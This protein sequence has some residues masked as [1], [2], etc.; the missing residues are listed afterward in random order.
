MRITPDDPRLTAYALDELGESE[1]EAIATELETSDECRREVE[2][3]IRTATL[4][5]AELA[6]EPLPELTYAQQL[7]IEAKLKPDANKTTPAKHFPIG[8]L[9]KGRNP[10]SR[11]LVFA[12]G[13]AV[14]AGIWLGLSSLFTGGPGTTALAQTLEQLQKARFITWTW[15]VYLH[16][17]SEDGQTWVG[18]DTYKY[19]YKAPGL[20][21]R[22]SVNDQVQTGMKKIETI[23]IIDTINRRMLSL[24]PGQKKA[25][26]QEV[27]LPLGEPEGPY[28]SVMKLLKGDDLQFVETRQTPTGEVNIFRYAKK[29][30]D[31]ASG[32]PWSYDYWIDSKTKQLVELRIPGSD[33]YDP[34]RDP[35]RNNSPGIMARGQSV[36]SVSSDY[37]FD[38]ELDESL[39]QLD[40]P[41]GYTVETIGRLNVT[42][43]E[44]IEFLGLLADYNDQT[45]PERQELAG[46]FSDGRHRRTQ[47]APKEERTAAEQKFWET[48]GHYIE[49]NLNDPIGEFLHHSTVENSFRYLGKGVRLGDAESIVCWY[50]LKGAATYRVVYG[51]LSVRDVAPE[52]LPLPV[53]R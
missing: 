33:I 10:I 50:K 9:F 23:Q 34:D 27:T 46:V 18:T 22:E 37:V 32:K 53:E 40:P 39:F 29:A 41:T 28:A 36:G 44:M 38:A 47:E 8:V 15:T 1:R 21:R 2:E 3:I 20:Y 43:K 12:A 24:I 11:G 14:L 25:T 45:F 52:D 13:A 6:A 4:L 42:E 7:A 19:A 5:S 16:W 48:L 30:K 17:S 35:A 51:D 26:L 49:I 31:N